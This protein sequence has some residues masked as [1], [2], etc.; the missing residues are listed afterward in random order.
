MPTP[1][2]VSRY[3]CTKCFER[4]AIEIPAYGPVP[5]KFTKEAREGVPANTV[6]V[7]TRMSSELAAQLDESRGHQPRSEWLRNLVEQ[8]VAS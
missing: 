2:S 4:T 8:S 1:K 3:G 7:T 5:G 6:V